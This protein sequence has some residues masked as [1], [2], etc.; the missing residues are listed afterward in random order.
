MQLLLI[1]WV[2]DH[3]ARAPE[4]Q[5]RAFPEIPRGR[6]DFVVTHPGRRSTGFKAL[7]AI[8]NG[9]YFVRNLNELFGD[10]PTLDLCW[11]MFSARCWPNLHLSLDKTLRTVES[12]MGVGTLAVGA[13]RGT[14]TRY[15]EFVLGLREIVERQNTTAVVL[16]NNHKKTD[17]FSSDAPLVLTH[18]AALRI[19]V[20]ARDA[21][22]VKLRGV[23]P[24][25]RCKL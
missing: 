3:C 20:M 4:P 18:S 11:P 12:R 8:T 21:E 15:S 24:G 25:T 10:E 17:P 6:L 23:T 13:I 9:G 16:F 7:D 19:R 2:C 1:T 22:V 5:L 14:G